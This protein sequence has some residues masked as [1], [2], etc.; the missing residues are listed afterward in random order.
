MV[1]TKLVT[2][3]LEIS[4]LKKSATSTTCVI[5]L[6]NTAKRRCGRNTKCSITLPLNNGKFIS[7]TSTDNDNNNNDTGTFESKSVVWAQ[8]GTQQG[9]LSVQLQN[10][11]QVHIVG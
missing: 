4:K 11:K 9:I 10:S 8:Q 1:H 7:N 2:F 5:K 3:P 6:C